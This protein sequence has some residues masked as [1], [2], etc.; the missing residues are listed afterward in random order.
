MLFRSLKEISHNITPIQERKL[1]K[2]KE[3][4]IVFQITDGASSFPGA[5]KKAVEEL[6]SKNV[7]VYAFQ[8]G[9]NSDADEKIFEFIWNEGYKDL[10]GIIIGEDVESLPKEL[11]KAVVQ[12]MKSIFI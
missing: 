12:N 10:H 5:A 7:L 1:K 8:I 9:K 3:I 11:L 6:L 4:K 2:G